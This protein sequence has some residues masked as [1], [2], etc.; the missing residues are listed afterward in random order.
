MKE[1]R[2]KALTIAAALLFTFSLTACGN[3]TQTSDGGTKAPA[4]TGGTASPAVKDLPIKLKIYAQYFDDDTKKP[5][6]Y[7]VAEL[8]KAMP[9]VE[10]ELDPAMQDNGQK[11][12]TYAASG[13]MP[14]IFQAGFTDLKAFSASKNIELLDNAAPTADFKKDLNPGN[15]PVLVAPDGH[16][17]AYPFAGIEFQILYY[18]K[19]L[20]AD[21]GVQAP[22]KTIDQWKDASAKFK[23]KGIV[24]VSIFSKEKWIGNSFYKGLVT[25]EEPNGYAALKGA[26]LPEAFKLA[27]KQFS[28]L[29]QAG[30]F[31]PNATNT[32]YDQA[33]SLFYTGKAAMF[34]NGQWEIYSADK[35]LGANVDWMYWPAK[36]EA[37]YEAK[38]FYMDGSGEPG[39]FSISATSKNK[40]TAIKVA[41]LLARKYAEYKYSQLGNP[42][43]SVKVDKPVSVTPP[44][45]MQRLIKET[46]PNVK[47]FAKLN[48]N[49]KINTAL[50]DN[51]QNLVVKGFS[52]QDFIKNMNR[53][54]S[55]A[56]K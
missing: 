9:N 46:L 11:L 24:P 6:D 56:N 37:T 13:N 39:G 12:R 31:D 15:E 43:V 32:N 5:Y 44:P 53:V 29:N 25:R 28:E 1:K 23:A 14:D 38:K 50:D 55:E 34:V 22:I 52:D 18:N 19:K 35:N 48:E 41:A 36:D 33:S 42:I 8:K 27:A 20:F 45:M 30:L 2:F 40:E 47:G 21:A 7:A 17:Y 51:T 16:I 49:I 10:L 3:G 54:L 26:E 4:N